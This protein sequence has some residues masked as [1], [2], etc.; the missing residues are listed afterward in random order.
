MYVYQVTIKTRIWVLGKVVW[1]TGQ[2]MG[3]AV[4]KAATSEEFKGALR[5]EDEPRVT[6]VVE[7]GKV[8]G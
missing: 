1:V 4:L 2:D 6:Q 5:S 8:A 7:C 3:E